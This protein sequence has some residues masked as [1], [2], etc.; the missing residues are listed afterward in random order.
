MLIY[1]QKQPKIWP[2][3]KAGF[4]TVAGHFYL[5]LF[6]LGLDLLLL[7]GPRLGMSGYVNDLL[8]RVVIPPQVSAEFTQ[9][10]TDFTASITEIFASFSLTSLLRSVPF[11]VPSLLFGE[12]FS[13]NPIG[14][15]RMNE[16]A[17]PMA[18]ALIAAGF[19]L[20]GL[21]VATIFFKL[22]ARAIDS[23]TNIPTPGGILPNFAAIL[24]I[25]VITFLFS[26]LIL[27]PALLIISLLV[28]LVPLIGT[29]GYF[30]LSFFLIS[31]I[32]PVIFV[33]HAITMDNLKF[34]DAL[35]LSMSTVRPTTGKSS[36][37]IFLCFLLSFLGD[38]LWKI[39]SVNTWAV[40][41]A[42]LGH[43]MLTTMLL[44]ASFHFFIDAVQSVKESTTM[45]E[46][47][48]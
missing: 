38:Q 43:A 21:F 30:L 29:I 16:V 46:Q 18:I 12:S 37:F 7:F 13:E 8:T 14:L 34:R 15:L 2:A 5:V 3:L 32:V 47:V 1:A 36:F 4:A 6:P 19:S 11:G 45:P 25:P 26:L 20:V 33:P 39:P 10:W 31:V 28:T 27:S 9:G 42:I 24:G 35:R 41:V 40:L 22:I 17:N 23:D 44:C 48:A